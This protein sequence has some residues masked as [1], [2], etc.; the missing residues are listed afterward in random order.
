MTTTVIEF[1]ANEVGDWF[2]HCHLLYHMKSGMARVVHY[3]EFTPPPTVSAVRPRLYHD[4]WY[5][6]AVAEVT[7]NMSEGM[8]VVANTRNIFTLD[9]EVGW[10]DVDGVHWEP[11]VS[12]DRYLDRFLSVFVGGDFEGI[13]TATE[14]ARAVLGVRYL[15]PLNFD[16]MV[17]VDSDGGWRISFEK[18][19]EITPRIGLHGE[20]QYDSHEK[21]EESVA[22]SYTVARNVALAVRWH[23]EYGT[24]AGLRLRF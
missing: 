2:F 7:S 23:S 21:W 3:E 5:L 10:Q 6:Y 20:A 16:S 22:L 8:V 14:S 18:E 12:Y 11:V 9:W 24:G 15:L 4:Q 1:P 19:L 17:W 13:D